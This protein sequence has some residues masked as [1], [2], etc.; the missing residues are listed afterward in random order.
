MTY[1]VIEEQRIIIVRYKLLLIIFVMVSVSLLGGLL[2]MIVVNENGGRMP[3]YNHNSF[4]R[5]NTHFT[6]NDPDKVEYFALTDKYRI[7]GFYYFSLGDILMTVPLLM[8]PY[9]FFLIPQLNPLKNPPRK[10]HNA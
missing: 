2:N 9:Y 1:R 3:V 5:T 8:V 10:S 6:F 4:Y 7:K